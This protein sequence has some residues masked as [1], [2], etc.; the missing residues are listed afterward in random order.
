MIDY[1][2]EDVAQRRE[3][4]GGGRGR[5][6][7][8]PAVAVVA[9]WRLRWWRAG[10]TQGVAAM[11]VTSSHPPFQKLL[12]LGRMIQNCLRAPRAIEGG[13]NR[14]HNLFSAAREKQL[15]TIEY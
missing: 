3:G 1:V 14:F 7:G 10:R 12:L 6:R 11:P 5:G 2:K 4:R 15:E 9:P 8:G 13:S